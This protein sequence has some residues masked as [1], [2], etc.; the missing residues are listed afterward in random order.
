MFWQ[1]SQTKTYSSVKVVQAL[2]DQKDVF[3]HWTNEMMDQITT[4]VL[5]RRNLRNDKFVRA[6]RVEILGNHLKL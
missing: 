1:W 5:Q 2:L 4:H 6:G 3:R